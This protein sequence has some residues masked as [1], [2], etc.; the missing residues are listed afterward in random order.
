MS[1]TAMTPQHNQPTTRTTES[2]GTTDFERL[3][4]KP[5]E[6]AMEFVPFGATDRIKLT[7]QVVQ[8]LLAVRTRSGA[9]CSD[10]DAM[11]FMMMCQ[12]QRLNPFAGDAFL[13]GYD[14]KNGPVFSLITA[15]VA[16]CKRAEACAD[17]E[18]M[19]SG[20]IIVLENGTTE[21]RQGDFAMPDEQVVGGWAKVYRKGRRPTLRRLSIAAM[22]PNY[23]TPFWN[24]LKAPGQIVKCAEADALRSTFPTLLGGLMT[25][26]EIGERMGS[27][28]AVELPANGLVEVQ[29]ATHR[30]DA[31][32]PDD[33][34]GDVAPA[35]RQPD[36]APAL[37]GQAIT[38]QVELMEVV[39][40]AGFD[41]NTFQRWGE[42][43]GSVPNA[44]SLPGF[45]EVPSAVCA[46]LLKAFR[47][48]KS[49]PVILQQLETAKGELV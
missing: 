17:Y 39:T 15:H 47:G 1:Q 23:E 32:A 16:L 4:Q 12:A 25:G 34:D 36:P 6:R 41:F 40:T 27:N 13:T 5:H 19:E 2:Q 26:E 24:D 10:R 43:S 31:P 8:K 14:S 42:S 46:S 3:L 20:V 22:K 28:V 30:T 33:N 18:G 9:T 11:R 44:S 38:P 29:G 48:A 35:K 21:D 49:R 45:R 7:V 37:E